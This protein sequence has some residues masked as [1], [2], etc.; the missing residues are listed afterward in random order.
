MPLLLIF[1]LILPSVAVAQSSTSTDI[2]DTTFYNSDRRSG[3]RQSIGDT[4][5]EARQVRLDSPHL[6]HASRRNAETTDHFIED[7]QRAMAMDDVDNLTNGIRGCGR[8]DHRIENQ[9][10]DVT[11]AL[12]KRAIDRLGCERRQRSDQSFQR[13]G[14]TG[15]VC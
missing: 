15:A 2:G 5:A 14:D 10:R 12:A 7:H 8:G 6:L 1:L 13:R 4:L 9:A 3:M 11:R